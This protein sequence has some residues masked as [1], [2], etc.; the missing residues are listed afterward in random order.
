MF[1]GAL[2]GGRVALHLSAAWLRRIFVVAV[3]GLAI[4]ML[5]VPH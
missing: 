1:I 4:R 5:V 2:L 3:L